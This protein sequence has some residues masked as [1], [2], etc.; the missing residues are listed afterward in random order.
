MGMV[1]GSSCLCICLLLLSAQMVSMVLVQ[2]SGALWRQMQL[3]ALS[4]RRHRSN[5]RLQLPSEESSPCALLGMVA[6]HYQMVPQLPAPF[7]ITCLWATV[8]AVWPCLGICN[9][10][11]QKA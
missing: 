3:I 2:D 10:H 9:G 7:P 8:L 4:Y 1:S 5:S 6:T 11:K